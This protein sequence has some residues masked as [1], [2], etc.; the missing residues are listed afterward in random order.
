MQLIKGENL[1][2][3]MRRQVYA[4]YVYRHLGIGPGKHY[5]TDNDWLIDHAF[6][7]TK[8]GRLSNKHNHCEPAFMAD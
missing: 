6:Y 2:E 3:D 4:A 5:A 8:A 1:T 7:F